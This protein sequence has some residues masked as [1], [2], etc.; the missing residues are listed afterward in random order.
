[1]EQAGST[2]ITPQSKK[3]AGYYSI[4][5]IFLS[6]AIQNCFGFARSAPPALKLIIAIF[7]WLA[8]LLAIGNRQTWKAY[9]QY[10]KVL[11][12]L[13]FVDVLGAFFHAIWSGEV[14]AGEKYVVIMTNMYATLNVISVLFVLVVTGFEHLRIILRGTLWLFVLNA[15]LLIF[16]FDVSTKSYFLS[17]FMIY[18]AIFLPYISRSKKLIFALGVVM[19]LFAFFGG[20][21]QVIIS[22]GFMMI[23]WIIPRYISKRMVLF[24]SLLL[25]VSPLFY[26][27]YYGE[28]YGDVFWQLEAGVED[29]EELSGNTRS[30]LY[31]EVMEDFLQRDQFTQLLGQGTLAYYNS[32]FFDTDSRF[33]VEVPIL[34]WIM[35]CG[36]LFYIIL[37]ILCVSAIIYIYTH[38]ENR[39]MATISILLGAYYFMCHVS[40][41]SGCN[42]MHLG[43]W[44]M[45]GMSFNPLFLNASDYD[46]KEELS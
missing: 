22:L 41:F 20:G 34:Q 21:R 26:V 36:L 17:Y 7:C 18:S 16:N 42:T 43:F 1:M 29:N 2:Y 13:L 37:T 24:L 11:L 9:P 27:W 15:L 32:R 12:I 5:F 28:F 31:Q 45:L 8:C 38:S 3:D 25:I 30:F 6:T 33:G 39:L 46:V 23:A 40:N 4:V 44:G 10:F 19:A 14:Y 35:Q